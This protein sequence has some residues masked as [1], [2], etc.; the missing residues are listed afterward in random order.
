MK[1]MAL[2]TTTTIAVG[3]LGISSVVSFPEPAMAD[4]FGKETEAPT[5]FT[6]ETVLV[7]L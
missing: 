7:R 2:A 6:G 4:E 3:I 1:K 5:L